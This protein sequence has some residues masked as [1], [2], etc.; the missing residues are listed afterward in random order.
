MNVSRQVGNEGFSNDYK[1]G[2][3]DIYNR[4]V[5]SVDDKAMLVADAKVCGVDPSSSKYRNK[6]KQIDW[7]KLKDD[8][9]KKQGRQTR[10]KQYKY[11][12]NKVK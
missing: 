12:Q 8:I 11:R 4:N 10:G 6:N 5:F 2:I 7:N 3:I 9:I 1:L